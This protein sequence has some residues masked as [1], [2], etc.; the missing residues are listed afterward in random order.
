MSTKSTVTIN[1]YT[2]LCT[3]YR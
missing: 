1:D 3:T 2:D